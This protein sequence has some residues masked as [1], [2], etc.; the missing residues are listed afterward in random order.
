MVDE[1]RFSPIGVVESCFPDNF[2]IPRQPGLVPA[3][4]G[5]VRLLAP[6]DQPEAVRGL[7]GFSHLWV[8]FVFHQ[9]KGETDKCTVRPPR[10]GGNTRLGVFASRATHRPNPIGLSLVKLEG[11]NQQA[12]VS[13]EVSGLDI[14]TGTPVLDIK[15]YLP[16]AESIDNARSGYA[17]AAPGAIEVVYSELARQQANVLEN[18]YPGFSALLT[19]VLA[20]D[21]R[22]AFH[23]QSSSHRQR[24]YGLTLY[25]Q[26]IRWH[27]LDDQVAEVI[28]MTPVEGIY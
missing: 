17:D 16:Y 18:R 23:Q 2:G 10:L 4:R 11:I 27:M 5:A 25:D 22:P 21:P 3:A 28:E 13:L 9:L 7:E 24:V 26:N 12:G 1:Y 6:Y 14:V 15:P 8:I 20:Q 19:Q